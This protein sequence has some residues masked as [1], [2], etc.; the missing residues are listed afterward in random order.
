MREAIWFWAFVCWKVFYYTFDFYAFDWSV[1]ILVHFLMPYTKI[2]SKW[3]EELNVR[4]ET[5][6][7]IHTPTA[8]ILNVETLKAFPLVTGT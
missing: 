6:G 4:P 1:Q 3:I 2:N 7:H 5:K 8:N